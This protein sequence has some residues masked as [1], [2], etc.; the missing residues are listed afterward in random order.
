MR[1]RIF[2]SLTPALLAAVTVVF[3]ASAALAVPPELKTSGNKVV[4]VSDGVSVTLRGSNNCS[5]EY[6]NWGAGNGQAVY[7]WVSQEFIGRLNAS[8]NTFG[9]KII[10]LPISQD[11]WMGYSD[12]EWLPAYNQTRYREQI[13]WIVQQC[14]DKNVYVIMDLHWSNMGSWEIGRASCRERVCSTV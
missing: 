11:R 8:L 9:V 2:V 12:N 1:N 5:L 10:R 6:S 14:A 13:D 7:P 4:R 3:L